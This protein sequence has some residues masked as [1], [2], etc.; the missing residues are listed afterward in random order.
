MRGLS[1]LTLIETSDVE[2]P[3]S[4]KRPVLVQPDELQ[5]RARSRIS[6]R[7]RRP[8]SARAKL[9]P[10]SRAQIGRTAPGAFR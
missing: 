9:S 1:E 7:R 10:R 8:H 2:F 3:V 5:Q 6:G 4:A